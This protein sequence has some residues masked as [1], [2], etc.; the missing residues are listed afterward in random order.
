MRDVALPHVLASLEPIWQDK[1]ETATRL[2]GRIESILD[3][4]TARGYREGLNPARWRGHLDKMLARPSK[5]AKRDHHTALPISKLGAF[6]KQLRKQEGLGARALE[7]VILTAARSGEVRGA[8]WSEIDLKQKV[9]TV[10][11]ERMKAGREHRVAPRRRG[12][13]TPARPAP[14]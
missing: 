3:W 2:R 12:H 4:A 11:G 9:W 13:E 8:K 10:A 1:T 7:F 14:T 5:V 6:M